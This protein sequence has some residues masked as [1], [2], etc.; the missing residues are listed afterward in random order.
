MIGFVIGT[1]CLVMLVSTVRRRHAY[2]AFAHGG[3]GD[4]FGTGHGPRGR[5]PG[6]PP[7]WAFGGGVRGMLR[8]LF[9]RLETTPGQEKA[10]VEEA[11]RLRDAV[12]DGTKELR[13]SRDDVARAIGGDVFDEA[14]LAAAYAKHDAAMARVREAGSAALARLHEVLDAEQRKTLAETVGHGFFARRWG[15]PYR[16]GF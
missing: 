2:H 15:G 11:N 3:W 8:G 6:F 13:E 5:Y 14:A 12:R 9:H 10:I 1:I 16:G 4:P 7:P